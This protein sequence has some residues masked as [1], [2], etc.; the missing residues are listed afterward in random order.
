M[1]DKQFYTNEG[2]EKFLFRQR[3]IPLTERKRF[4]EKALVQWEKEQ[5]QKE[6]KQEQDDGT[7]DKNEKK[8]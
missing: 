8:K 5:E 1:L 2:N 7:D 6:T 4:F 3:S